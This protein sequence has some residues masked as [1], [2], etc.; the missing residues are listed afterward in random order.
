MPSRPLAG[1]AISLLGGLYTLVPHG[2]IRD[3]GKWAIGIVLGTLIVARLILAIEEPSAA[4]FGAI[5]GI[6]IG[7][8]AFRMFLP[9]DG[10]P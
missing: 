1:L 6:A 3:A 9:N 2:R 7:L 10:S 4:V 8:T 5:L